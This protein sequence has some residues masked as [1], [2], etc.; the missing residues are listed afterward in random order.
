MH[1]KE[2]PIKNSIAS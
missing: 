1:Q 2:L